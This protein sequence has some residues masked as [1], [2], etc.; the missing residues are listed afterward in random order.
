MAPARRRMG[1]GVGASRMRG[2]EHLRCDP[3]RHAD[4]DGDDGSVAPERLGPRRL[5]PLKRGG[6]PLCRRQHGR[7][8]AAEPGRTCPVERAGPPKPRPVQPGRPC[9]RGAT[10]EAVAL[11]RARDARATTPSRPSRPTTTSTAFR[12]SRTT[13]TPSRT[14]AGL[15]LI[16]YNIPSLTGVDL[17]TDRLLELLRRPAGR[18]HQIHR[19]GRLPVHAPA[20]TRCQASA[21][22]S[23]PTRCSSPPRRRNR[24][25]HRQHLQPDRRRLCRH[26]RRGRTGRHRDRP[27]AAG[28]GQRPDR[29]PDPDRRD[30]R[31]EHALNR[32]GIP[33]GPCRRPFRPPPRTPS[34][35]SRPGS[36]T[37]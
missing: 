21:S 7:M 36:T 3:R 20:K 9:R 34:A 28:Q 35:S 17:G 25:R 8:R 33:V 12:R 30:P 24:R 2:D 32:L 27:H 26:P 5:H 16:V 10:D 37:I 11:A 13:T 1:A 23:A 19:Q 18:R 6:R 22:I 14:A 15:P 4:A 31:P 29:N